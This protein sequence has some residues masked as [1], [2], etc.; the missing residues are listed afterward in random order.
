MFAMLLEMI[1][2]F[3]SWAAMPVEAIYKACIWVLSR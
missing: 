1:S 3:R 2:T